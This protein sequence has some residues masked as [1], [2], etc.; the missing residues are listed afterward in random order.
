MTQRP[1]YG[2]T[3]QKWA[4]MSE[5]QQ[6]RAKADFERLAKSREEDKHREQMDRDM[7]KTIDMDEP[8]ARN[9]ILSFGSAGLGSTAYSLAMGRS[10]R[11]FVA[12]KV[13]H[14]QWEER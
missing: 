13:L 6:A 11:I 7:R 10:R 1:H 8:V 3:E 14:M 12:T 5:D 9:S 2:H 4:A